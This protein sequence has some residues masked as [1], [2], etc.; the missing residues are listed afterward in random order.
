MSKPMLNKRI[1]AA[2]LIIVLLIFLVYITLPFI[3]AFFG[4]L[5]LFVMF[6]PLNH[7]IRLKTK[8]KVE[9]SAIITILVS[10]VVVIVPLVF[11][12]TA[13][14]NQI[15]SLQGQ[16]GAINSVLDNVQISLGNEQL[17]D[18][19]MQ[20]ATKTYSFIQNTLLSVF[21]RITNAVVMLFLTYFIM[22]YLLVYSESIIDRTHSIIP[23][24][25]KNS[26]MLIKEFYRITYSTVV[27][28]GLIA[29][30]QGVLLGAGFYFL[31][32]PN[33]LFWTF[34]AFILAFLPVVGSAILWVPAGLFYVLLG[35]YFVG[36]SILVWGF[37]V[38]NIDN[39][40]RPWLNN[41]IGRI[42]PL[43]SVVGVFVGLSYFGLLG[44]FIGPL[45]ISYVLLMWKMYLEEYN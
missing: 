14:V 2:V 36:I 43:I 10:L 20:I 37:V 13:L 5:I 39:V 12:I 7:W 22:F 8:L 24:N 1:V 29:F 11:A 4:A 34:I 32:V 26:K 41:K 40:V 19:L 17:Q 25:L 45:L 23:F 16:I 3:G 28:S 18:A 27:S 21:S 35:N 15:A 44:I 33:A 31:G 30:L 42:H 6:K 38:S 9:Y